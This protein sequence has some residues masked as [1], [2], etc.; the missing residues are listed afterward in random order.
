MH[1]LLKKSLF[2]DM[3]VKFREV[4][5]DIIPIHFFTGRK[6]RVSLSNFQPNQPVACSGVN[7]GITE[8]I[9]QQVSTHRPRTLE[10]MRQ[11]VPKVET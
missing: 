6:K 10:R 7:G 8:E 1:F 9:P 11:A 4:I 5:Y 3:L 2:R